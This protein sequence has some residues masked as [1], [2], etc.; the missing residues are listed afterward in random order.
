MTDKILSMAQDARAEADRQDLAAAIK[1]LRDGEVLHR[2]TDRGER[3]IAVPIKAAQWIAEQLE[4]IQAS[5]R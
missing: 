4:A 5:R 2:R 3:F 1:I